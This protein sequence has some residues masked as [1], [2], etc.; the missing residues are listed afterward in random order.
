MN[1]KEREAL[2][3]IASCLYDL[4]AG[5]YITDKEKDKLCDIAS[6][7]YFKSLDQIG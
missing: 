5:I 3:I 7:K 6:G 2:Q 4:I 1:E